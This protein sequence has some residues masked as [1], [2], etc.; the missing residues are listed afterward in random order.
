MEAARKID[1]EQAK[2]EAILGA[3]KKGGKGKE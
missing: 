1:D 2:L 3:E